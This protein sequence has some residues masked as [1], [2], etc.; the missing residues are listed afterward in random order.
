MLLWRSRTHLWRNQFSLPLPAS[1]SPA[2]VADDQNDQAPRHASR[3]AH[4]YYK[5]RLHL[6]NM[7][8]G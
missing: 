4:I 8:S 3:S 6:C 5:I 2:R 1:P 7:L